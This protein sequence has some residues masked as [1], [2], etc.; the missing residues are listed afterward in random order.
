MAAAAIGLRSPWMILAPMFVFAYGC[1]LTRPIAQ[2][3]A[4]VPFAAMAG[5][6]SAVLGFTQLAGAS[7]VSVAFNGLLV[8]GP[9]TMT[10][11]IAAAAVSAAF[12]AWTGPGHRPVPI[13]NEPVPIETG[14][15]PPD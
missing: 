4:L 11:A 15:A 2:A 14:P 7:L 10:V 1:G 5:L 12:V 3:S 9:V 8:P 13:E 6:A